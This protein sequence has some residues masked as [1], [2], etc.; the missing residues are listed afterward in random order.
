MVTIE[1]DQHRYNQGTAGEQTMASQ[2]TEL[3]SRA[4][5]LNKYLTLP[6]NT[7]Q[8]QVTYIWIDGTGEGLRAKSK[9]VDK[10]PTAPNQLSVWNFDGSSTGE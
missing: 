3:S 8:I 10:V 7:D 9:T 5:L 1:S 2:T 4:G 6:Q